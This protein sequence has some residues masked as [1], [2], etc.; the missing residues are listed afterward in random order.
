MVKTENKINFKFKISWKIG[1][2][3]QTFGGKK[4]STNNW[5]FET[6]KIWLMILK[7]HRNNE[8]KAGNLKEKISWALSKTNKTKG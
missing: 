4:I 7:P 5:K 2:Q 1:G 3:I 6:W 8:G